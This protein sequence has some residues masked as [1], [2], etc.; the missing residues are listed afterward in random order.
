M[1][2]LPL[3]GL[4]LLAFAIAEIALVVWVSGQIG[5]GWTLLALLA[6]AAL[7]ILLWRLEGARA[8]ESLRTAPDQ[9]QASRTVGDAVLVFVGGI[10]LLVPGFLSDALGLLCILPFTRPL[11]RSVVRAAVD[12]WVQRQRARVDLIDAHLRPDT[13]VRG[14]AVEGPGG[15]RRPRPD[16]PTVIRGSVEP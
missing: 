3:L 11:V 1:R 13:V 7:G 16:D 10:L 12:P 15:P 5:I 8:L 2:R 6:T 9:A 4:G 14:E